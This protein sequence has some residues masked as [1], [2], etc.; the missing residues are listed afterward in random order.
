MFVPSKRRVLAGTDFTK[1]WLIVSQIDDGTPNGT[2]MRPPADFDAPW[3]T[4]DFAL[5]E[6]SQ[7]WVDSIDG[8]RDDTVLIHVEHFLTPPSLHHADLSDDAP[9]RPRA[10]PRSSVPAA[11][12]P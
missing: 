6:A 10:F 8:E 2:L 12:P 11:S 5:P 7:S 1:H 9:W 4:R 3:Q